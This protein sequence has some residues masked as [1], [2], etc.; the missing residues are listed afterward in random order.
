LQGI[1]EVSFLP[2][3]FVIN[4]KIVVELLASNHHKYN[5]FHALLQ[6][7]KLHKK[8]VNLIATNDKIMKEFFLMPL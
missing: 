7:A 2:G 1:L 4:R 6:L 8:V 5:E 3:A